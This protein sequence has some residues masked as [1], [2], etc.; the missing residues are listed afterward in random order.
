M[1]DEEF[2]GV[3]E[4]VWIASGLCAVRGIF[5]VVDREEDVV[6]FLYVKHKAIGLEPR[7][8]LVISCTTFVVFHQPLNADR[9][10]RE[11]GN[12]K[13]KCHAHDVTDLAL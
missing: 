5:D 13:L 4:C 9:S 2:D 7:I 3:V 10:M 11:I 8:V 6:F 1:T 12:C